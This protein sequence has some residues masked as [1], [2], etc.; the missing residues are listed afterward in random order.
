[1]SVNHFPFSEHDIIVL[2]RGLSKSINIPGIWKMNAQT[3]QTSIFRESLEKLWPTWVSKINDSILIWWVIIK[4]NIKQLT[5]E[6]SKT[7]KTSKFQLAKIEK[8]LN[9]IKDSDRYIHR[10]ASKN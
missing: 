4:V 9:E 10:N 6:V 8:Q 2:D 5:V 3:I 1:M 7:L